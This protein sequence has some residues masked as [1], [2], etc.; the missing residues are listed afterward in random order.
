MVPPDD[1]TLMPGDKV[2]IRID[3]IGTLTN[4]VVQ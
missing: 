2:S 4:T 3:H 1:F